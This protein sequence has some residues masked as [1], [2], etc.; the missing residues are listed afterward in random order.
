MSQ[1]LEVADRTEETESTK[2][3]RKRLL[4]TQEV[5]AA[6]MGTADMI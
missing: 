6:L 4:K 2:R 1:V 3:G 5:V